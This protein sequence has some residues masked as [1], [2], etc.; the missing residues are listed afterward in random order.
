MVRHHLFDGDEGLRLCGERRPD[1]GDA[2]AVGQ[3]HLVDQPGDHEGGDRL[4]G[5]EHR[6]QGVGG[7]RSGLGAVGPAAEQVDDNLAV[8]SEG[9][10]GAE[11]QALGEV[12]LERLAH[13]GEARGAEPRIGASAM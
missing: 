8:D 4:G 5:R 1:L 2:L 6:G 13:G 12:G 7:E 11:L 3:L 9:E 10:A